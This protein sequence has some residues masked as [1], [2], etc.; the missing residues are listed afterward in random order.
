[1]LKKVRIAVALGV[2]CLFTLF[3]LNIIN[4]GGILAKVQ[5]IP[6]LL[7]ANLLSFMVL[8]LITL[9][10]GRIYCSLICPLGI[11]QDMVNWLVRKSL[12]KKRPF[13]YHRPWNR[14]RYSI[15]I[16]VALALVGGVAMLPG[17]LDPYSMYG[18]IVT[19]LMGPLWLT[20]NNFLAPI[21]ERHGLY[22]LMKQLIYQQG[23][24]VFLVA[25][26]SLFI[27]AL[28]A[29]KYGRLYCNTLCPVGAWLSV[30]SRFSLFHVAVDTEKCNHCGLCASNCKAGCI[31]SKQQQI[32]HSRCVDCF[33]C[34]SACPQ[35]ALFFTRH[36]ALKSTADNQQ[37]TDNALSRRQFLKCGMISAAGAVTMVMQAKVEASAEETNKNTP[38]VLPPG[39]ESLQRFSTHCTS[40][41]LCVN[42]C[43][44]QVIQ[45]GKMNKGIFSM[46]QPVMDYQ[47]GYCSYNCHFCGE[48]CPTQALKELSLEQKRKMKIGQAV[49]TRSRC[50]VETDGVSCGNCAIHC[51]TKAITLI[52][53]KDKKIP[54]IDVSKCI[55]CGSCEYHCPA[56]PRAMHVVGLPKQVIGQVS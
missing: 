27:V 16:V 40:C 38:P 11:L 53:D 26:A 20:I 56:N 41:H 23:Q 37:A 44:N 31:D 22:Y 9:L 39:G 24:E 7:A 19:H 1:M 13:A 15:L 4:S 33:N 50:V 29:G 21:L 6:S 52:A 18:R 48:I 45:P 54:S 5:I 12:G 55:G 34:L 14:L 32:D 46:L 30:L 35:G 43:P 42:K 10:L 28:I 3:F 8:S 2:F 51:P 49:Y 25:L 47:K 17:L 36:T